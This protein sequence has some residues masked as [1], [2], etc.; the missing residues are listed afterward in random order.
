M[1]IPGEPLVLLF[2]GLIYSLYWGVRYV[3]LAV[4]ARWIRT[5]CHAAGAGLREGRG[6]GGAQV[7]GRS[8]ELWARVR[9]GLV[10]E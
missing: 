4:A 2:C 7:A 1:T 8:G 6:S 5:R 10:E 3:Y 9:A